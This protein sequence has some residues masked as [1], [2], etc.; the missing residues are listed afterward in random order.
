MGT[1]GHTKIGEIIESSDLKP[2][3]AF[4]IHDALVRYYQGLDA[5]RDALDDHPGCSSSTYYRWRDSHPEIVHEIELS[6]RREAR[7]RV[8]NR[9]AAFAAEQSEAS[10][11]IQRWAMRAL[12]DTDVRS[13][14]IATAR[15]EIEVIERQDGDDK[16]IIPYPRDR[17][18]AVEILQD[19]ARGGA[20][21]EATA[22]YLHAEYH[23]SSDDDEG[24][25]LEDLGTG[26]NPNFREASGDTPDGRKVS[27]RIND[28]DIIEGEFEEAD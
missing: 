21:P 22:Q 4:A 14:L 9:E 28:D 8:S 2:K 3:S 15:G 16:E 17:M 5:K 6:A 1:N 7:D 12:Q 27:R 26:G 18:R 25:S 11:D 23:E 24:T 19:L 13:S 10:R 20:L